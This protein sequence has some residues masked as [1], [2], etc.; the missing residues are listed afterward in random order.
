[1]FLTEFAGLTRKPRIFVDMDG[2]LADFFAGY[3]RLNPSVKSEEEMPDEY[4]PTY[5]K[6]RDTD[7]FYRLPKYASA[8]QLIATVLDFV[9]SYSILTAPIHGD[10]A[11]SK[12][13][14][15]KWIQKYLTPQ[16]K[17]I[18]V[19][20][21]KYRHAVDPHTGQFNILIDDR[22]KNIDPWNEAGGVAI[23]YYAPYDDVSIVRKKLEEVLNEN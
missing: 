5:E 13:W 23:K 15:T 19:T 6:M 4:D 12:K 17:R 1:M 2:V 18:I 7:F 22:D 21:H 3:Q 8:D 14:K 11:N 10:Y 20:S 16:P 9:P